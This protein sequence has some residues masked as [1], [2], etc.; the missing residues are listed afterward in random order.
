MKSLKCRLSCLQMMNGIFAILRNLSTMNERQPAVG[1]TAALRG[2]NRHK[3]TSKDE[4]E[5]AKTGNVQERRM[6]HRKLSCS[7][8]LT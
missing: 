2:C 4:Q 6:L 3:K 5:Q 1:H 7:R 8:M